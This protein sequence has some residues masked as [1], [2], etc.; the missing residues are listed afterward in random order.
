MFRSRGI[1]EIYYTRKIQSRSN[2][3]CSW[4][5]D[6]DFQPLLAVACG[7]NGVGVYTDEG[8][9]FDP[10]K[11][12]AVP[13]TRQSE[14]VKLAWHPALPLLVVGWKDGA[15][16]FW[17]AEES[18][19]ASRIK[20]ESATHR[21][22]I[23]SLV[24]SEKGDRLVTTDDTG[25]LTLWGVSVPQQDP[26]AKGKKKREI[27]HMMLGTTE[28]SA[29]RVGQAVFGSGEAGN[30]I[31]YYGCTAVGRTILKWAS[32]TAGDSKTLQTGNVL[33]LNEELHQLIYYPERNQLLCITTNSTLM[34]V[35]KDEMGTWTALSKMKF[36]TGTGEAATSLQVTWAG[37]HTLA[38]A[39]EKDAVVRMYNFDTEDNYVLQLEPDVSG[40]MPRVVAVS[41]D[42]RF[43]LL[44][45][46]SVEG[47]VCVYRF[48]APTPDSEPLLDL[49]RCW[50]PQP[51]FSIGGRPLFMEWG[52]TQSHMVVAAMDNV[53]M[54]H[55]TLLSHRIK[56]GLVVIQASAERLMVESVEGT[57][58]IP[59]KLSATMQI[60]SIDLSRQV[61]LIYDGKTV[62]LYK[63]G[64]NFEL[65][66]SNSFESPAR[67]VALHNESVYR[68]VENR[69]EVCNFSGTVKQTLAFEE[70]QGVPF[71]LDINK[72]FLAVATTGNVVRVFKLSG[73][74]AKPHAGPGH[75]IPTEL[76]HLTLDSIRV[77][78]SGQ[79]VSAL[80]TNKG[81]ARRE[82]KMFVFAA[83]ASGV[84]TYDFGADSR[85]PQ[86]HAWDC[87]EPK[88]L[89]V[90]TQMHRDDMMADTAS[91][92]K[93]DG[94]NTD[95]ALMFVSSDHGIR[96][97]EYQP[98][99]TTGT[100]G[101]VGLCA[102]YLVVNKKQVISGATSVPFTSNIQKIVMQGFANMQDVDEKTRRA[103]LDFSFNLITGNMDEA[104]RS[105]KAIR[106]PAVWENMAHL[107]IKNK[108]LDVAEH[109]LG[110]MEHARGARAVRE[111]KTIEELDARVGLVAVHLGMVEDAKKLFLSSERYDLLNLLYR[112]SGQWDKALEIAEKHDRIH[113]TST[114]YVYARHL[115]DVGDMAAAQKQYESSKTAAYEIPRLLFQSGK[116]EDLEKYVF[117]VNDKESLQ[118]WARYSESKGDMT[119]ALQC[120][121]AAGDNLSIV[122]IHCYSGAFHLARQYEVQE[123]ISEA[124]KYYT[125]SRRYSHGVRLAKKFDLDSDLMNLALK[126]TQN[127]MVDTA[128]YLNEKGDYDKAATLYMKGGK[129]K[130][131]V[132]MCFNARLFDVLQNIA[133]DLPADSD[134]HLLIRCAEFFM[135]HGQY[136]KAVKMLI[137]AGQFSRAL[138]MCLEH[139]IT[140]TEEMAEAMSPDKSVMSAE[141]RGLVL[142][143]IA[144][145]CKRQ[146]S[147]HL[148][149]KKYTQA[150]D[151]VKAMKA[152]IKSGDS[153]KIVFFAGVSRQRD[154]YLM[155]ANYLQTLDWHSDPEVMKN[156]IN[157]YTKAQAMESLS[158]FY[159][160]CA[161]IE[162][163]EYRDYEK[164]LQAMHESLKHMTKSKA[165]DREAR[166]ASINQ[167]IA[168]TDR[169][170]QARRL[171]TQNPQQAIGI[172]HELL[173]QIPPDMQ[174]MDAGIRIG[175]V[176]ALMVEYWYEQRNAEEAF[177]LIEQM[178]SRGIILAPYLDQRMVDDIHKAL[179]IDNIDRHVP[180]QDE[181]GFID[182]DVP[183]DD[184]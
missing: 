145:C 27:K 23:T 157:F 101:Y 73:R 41:Y 131:A 70:S 49:G 83:E 139:D 93:R 65:T 116:I 174:E 173:T 56:D 150:G 53:Y 67:A 140:I 110:N 43:N 92:E 40:A 62:E 178:R 96:L 45:A 127:V 175:D 32:K 61:L 3:V 121:E 47:K 143:R 75:I 146:G 24:F 177:R 30:S 25:K 166:L 60:T 51:S 134:P 162:I 129:L 154:I 84:L 4:S 170:V 74:E 153:E 167:R 87:N 100:G 8:K 77:N 90:Q 79:L 29:S 156:I 128:D 21:S 111:A 13:N 168:M 95:V 97:Q 54:C 37:A 122:R 183:Q 144:K 176:F 142:R 64:D 63:I 160:A 85:E 164:A 148:A 22:A 181:G 44:A 179:G 104:F 147:Y 52:P 69:V 123:R 136:A 78:A 46:G 158:G 42:A 36:A 19:R 180:L 18:D 135:E 99:D 55:K 12:H 161:Q 91:K 141:E 38:S 39:S 31:V 124:I 151:K 107:C 130:K 103:L 81:T 184:D 35:G 68:A 119:K 159:E 76:P 17:N 9:P 182:E 33:E 80:V 114:H 1:M 165:V 72:D 106:N 138:D 11:E 133:D 14:C 113:L 171:I 163:D 155:A 10:A 15:V 98:I 94:S 118:W 16:S 120:Y 88:M 6:L 50:E 26:S 28:E 152:L 48:K 105:V 20:E 126:S 112:A 7:I 58:K 86:V 66:Q 102:P 149:C 57:T 172:C 59:G 137:P 109:C 34:V 2:G 108:R 115:E 117:K 82:D 125:M 71:L 89:S 5:K 169:F 132:D